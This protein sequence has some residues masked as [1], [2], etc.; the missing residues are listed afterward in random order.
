MLRAASKVPAPNDR[1]VF[2]C[3]LAADR[4]PIGK[5]L[6]KLSPEHQ[7]AI[8]LFYLEGMT[9]AEVAVA[10]DI[11]LGTVKSRLMHARGKLRAAL[12][13]EERGQA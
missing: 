5:A 11:P 8:A 1:A 12:E 6:A 13:G 4:K 2:D 9:V 3:E 7:A 10:L